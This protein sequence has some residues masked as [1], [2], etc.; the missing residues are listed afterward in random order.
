[1]RKLLP[2]L[3]ALL[4]MAAGA[5]AQ[6][7]KNY[8]LRDGGSTYEPGVLRVKFKEDQAP[9]LDV[10]MR[11]AEKGRTLEARNG[12]LQTGIPGLDVANETVG[13]TKMTRVFRPAGKFEDRHRQWGLHLWY[14]M[15]FDNQ[16]QLEK[17]LAAYADLEVVQIAEPK[18]AYHLVDG[19]DPMLE[20]KEAVK[21]Y[22]AMS[23]AGGTPNDPGYGQ[24]WGYPAINAP[25][26]WE[27]ETGNSSVVVAI[28][29]GGVDV[30][31]AD[32]IGNM[33]INTG[34]VPGDGIDN[35]NNGYVDDVNGYNFGDNTGTVYGDSHGSHVGGTVAAET[36]NGV[37]VAGTA[38]GSGSNDGVRLMTLSV[39][40]NSSNG[41]F[42]EAFIYAADM[43]AAIS[44]NSWGGGAQSSAIENAI[45]YFRANGGGSVMDGGLPIF[46]AGNDN[47]SSTS[48]G[49]PASYPSCLAVA[50]VSSSLA[51]SSFSNYGS[52][53]DISAPGS[54]I[55][56]TFPNNN[57]SSIS[58]TSM[59][60]PHVSGVAALVVS[61][62]VNNNEIITDEELWSLLV[63]NANFDALYNAN[64][65]YS[66]QLGSGMLDAYASLT[67]VAAPPPPCTESVDD[68]TLTLVTDNYGSETSWT[69]KNASGTTVASGSGYAN[70]TT[71][72]E[73][74]SGLEG[75]HTFTITDS[76]GD[77]IC[78][79]YGSGSYNLTDSQNTVIVSGG[80]FGSS[81][82]TKFCAS[83]SGSGGGGGSD[84]T[85]SSPAGYC[86]ADG[87]STQ[88][89][90][91]D[92]VEIQGTG[93]SRTSSG[94]GGYYN[95]TS[96]KGN[97]VTGNTYTI[98]LSAG[99]A[100]TTYSENWKFYADWNRDGDFSDA[101]ED[102]GGGSTSDG[103]IYSISMSVPATASL[104]DTRF[105]A[106]MRW[107]T[108][109]VACGNSSYGEVEDFTI[110]VCDSG[111]SS[112][113]TLSAGGKTLDQSVVNDRISLYPNPTEG[114]L[115]ID[116]ARLADN[117]QIQITDLAGRTMY[118]AAAK[119]TG[120]SVDVS[121]LRDGMYLI[122]VRTGADVITQKF[123]KK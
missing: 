99:F 105:R 68:V 2:I 86:A 96:I 57:Y 108:A 119:A 8:A 88:Y 109:A 62:K 71:Y 107:N 82:S 104:G 87:G 110:N 47:T 12:A 52:W 21:G 45:D 34:E 56:S 120:N 103:N 22:E 55:Y 102:V 6:K 30:D 67:G 79:S 10:L 116:V 31:H 59:A 97:L 115:N 98:R 24:Q 81:Q 23:I 54:S 95:G 91:I 44:Q 60:C 101:G 63:D 20:R 16:Q 74:F 90:W 28:E 111:T 29:D 33:W 84:C 38:G 4:I 9:K 114:V 85:G 25:Q 43:G 11:M 83:Q 112:V 3:A 121:N 118:S 100:G 41:G 35:D 36:N 42:D 92:L 89:E 123:Y 40:G 51:K 46:A 77:G 32:L 122:Q 73:V 93:L 1:M 80:A 78:C 72:T 18:I 26:A 94:D 15:K 14:E 53:V 117:A 7:K 13:A 17:A 76:Y 61:Y 75:E 39:F 113:S 48:Y 49:Y 37:G 65:S 66:G 70:N 64:S 50:S 58:G 19:Y 5:H 69:L 106:V 27:L